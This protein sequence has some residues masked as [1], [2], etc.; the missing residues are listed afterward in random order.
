MLSQRV[1]RWVVALVL[2]LVIGGALFTG[3]KLLPRPVMSNEGT[4][5]QNAVD[6][7]PVNARVLMIFDYEPALAGEMEAVSGAMVDQII[8]LHKPQLTVLSTSP[9][10][11]A[12]A[13][14]FMAGS[15]IRKAYPTTD[16]GFLP[17][18]SSGIQSFVTNAQA[19]FAAAQNVTQF[20]DYA[21]II[22]ITDRAET[23]RAWVEQTH[24]KRG[25]HPFLVVSSA[26]SAPMIQPY[27]LSGQINGLVTGLHDGAAFEQKM[28]ADGSASRYWDAY[29]LSILV[30]CVMIVIGGL[31]NFVLGLRSRRQ[32]L[33]EA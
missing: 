30:A 11:T 10:G 12:L 31:W 19:T 5:A 13:N 9:T 4:L 7:L 33:D 26:Q 27:L 18:E 14:H 28:L 23:A 17:G 20:S 32:G 29:N 24:G 1:L 15:E 8:S 22:L 21:M 25:D 16:L 2:L 3:V 6:A